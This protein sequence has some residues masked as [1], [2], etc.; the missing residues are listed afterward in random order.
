MNLTGGKIDRI[1]VGIHG[2]GGSGWLRWW[3]G[4]HFVN[5]IDSSIGVVIHE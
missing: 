2:M 3:V 1:R 4:I 5:G